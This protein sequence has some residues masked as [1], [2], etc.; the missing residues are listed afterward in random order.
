MS[1]HNLW[2]ECVDKTNDVPSC[3]ELY[4]QKIKELF[5]EEVKNTKNPYPKDVFVWDNEEPIEIRNKQNLI[6]VVITRGRFNKF[7]HQVVENTKQDIIKNMEELEYV[8]D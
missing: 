1:I 2:N 8:S 3:L 4:T 7:I 5:I 6:D